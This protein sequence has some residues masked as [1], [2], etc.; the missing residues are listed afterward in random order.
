MEK[1]NDTPIQTTDAPKHAGENI[2]IPIAIVIAGVLIGGAILLS[3]KTTPSTLPMVKAAPQDKVGADEKMAPVDLLALKSDDHIL[4]NPNADVLVIEYSDA[5]CPF[6]KKFHET[7][8]EIME[9]YGKSGQVAWVYRHF[10]LDQLHPKARKEG[11]AMECANEQGG[12]EA[13]WKF[14]DKLFE[15]TPAN[16]GLDASQLPIIAGQVGLD[17]AKFSECLASG[18][19]AGRVDRDFV[20]G[21][22]IGVKGTPYSVVWNTKTG[23]QFP[24]NGAYPPENVRNILDAAIAPPSAG[25]KN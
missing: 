25:A 12:N 8:V 20:N 22:N 11:E 5:E 18:K 10:P 3:S 23:K 2:S 16:N 7:M 24:M 1:E 4:G 21:A 19:F 6:C 14:S 13:F 9:Q 17:V 15:V